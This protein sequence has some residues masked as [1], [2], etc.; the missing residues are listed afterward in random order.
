MILQD[1]IGPD[2]LAKARAAVKSCPKRALSLID[3]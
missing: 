3:D 2:L 1:T